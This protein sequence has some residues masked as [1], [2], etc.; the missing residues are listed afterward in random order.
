MPDISE[1]Y[2]LYDD[3]LK[4]Y[5]AILDAINRAKDYVFLE[6]YRFN[7]DSIGIKFRD[8]LTRKAKEGVKVMLLMDSWGTSLP[9]SFFLEMTKSGGQIR[10]FK[11]IKFFWNFFTYNHRRNHRKIIIIDEL[12]YWYHLWLPV[13]YSNFI[14][15]WSI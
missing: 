12:V 3:P 13:Y 7:N 1:K 4:F 5:N 9:T 10:F 14:T 8:A 6:T 2:K 15:L 11:K